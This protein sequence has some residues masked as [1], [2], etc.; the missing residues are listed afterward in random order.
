M[1][2]QKKG[3]RIFW[4]F[5]RKWNNFKKYTFNVSYTKANYSIFLFEDKDFITHKKRHTKNAVFFA[6][7]CDDTFYSK[8]DWNKNPNRILKKWYKLRSNQKVLH[9]NGWQQNDS[10]ANIK[11][12]PIFLLLRY[13]VHTIF[14]QKKIIEKIIENLFNYI[15]L[16]HTEYIFSLILISNNVTYHVEYSKY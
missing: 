15:W 5:L 3:K 13:H 4:D 8:V 11:Y 7:V 6:V 16:N 14:V 10:H 2:D 1:E 9:N 12:L